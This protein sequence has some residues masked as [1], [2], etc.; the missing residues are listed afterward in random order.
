MQTVTILWSLIVLVTI[1]LLFILIRT[2]SFGKKEAR[3]V[4]A[5]TLSV[6]GKR[7]TESLSK[8]IQ[9]Q[10]ISFR[11]GE[12]PDCQ[13]LSKLRS[14][15]EQQFPLMHQH[16]KKEL[17]NE[18]ALLYTW[19]G[20]D[21]S[22]EPVLFSAHQDVVPVDPANRSLWSH[23]PFSGIVADGFVWGR[24][25]MDMKGMLISIVEAVESLLEQGFHPRRTI[26]LAFGHDEE[27]G[28]SAGAACIAN[29]LANRGIR[30]AALWD[31]GTCM[32][33]NILPGIDQPVAIIGTAE[34]GYLTVDFE[35]EGTPGHASTPPKETAVSTLAAAMSKLA[36]HSMPVNLQFIQAL[37]QPLAYLLPFKLRLAFANSRLLKGM[38]V[39]QLDQNDQTAAAIRTT[40]A[41]TI[42]QG[43]VKDNI[44]PQKANATVN[45]RILPG[46]T[47]QDVLT[48]IEAVIQDKRV[49]FAP[50]A[51]AAWDP[52]AAGATHTLFYDR[53][54]NAVRSVFENIPAAPFMMTGATDSRHYKAITDSI[55][56]FS[57]YLADSQELKRIHG[58]DERISLGTLNRISVFAAQ[59]IHEWGIK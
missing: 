24:G 42:F 26:L 39:S 56:R 25:T 55:Y 6:N 9:C 44:L 3:P 4:P 46:E 34:K 29:E 51:N 16:L 19:Q 10:T 23:D 15:L 57:P 58:I 18:N 1:L 54:V 36:A 2:F 45:F 21:P 14:L 5:S 12:I 40:T 37:M 20:S 17:I 28:G 49:H 52:V 33:K 8:A 48:H 27:V 7:L 59:L 11:E 43:G 38:I 35:V 53:F 50:V 32:V 13:E 41:V 31:E 30:L 47:V 22:L